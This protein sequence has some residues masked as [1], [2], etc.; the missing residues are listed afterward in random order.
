MFTMEENDIIALAEGLGHP[1]Y[2][3]MDFA[4]ALSGRTTWHILQLLKEIDIEKELNNYH[5]EE[6]SGWFKC[7]E[8]VGKKLTQQ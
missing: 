3:D 5:P 8:V 6:A 1:A 2:L 7:L 4:K